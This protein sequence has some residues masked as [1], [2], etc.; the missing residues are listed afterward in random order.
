[1][2][3]PTPPAQ[4]D[5]RT[6]SSLVG[7]TTDARIPITN[8]VAPLH[9]YD[10]SAFAPRKQERSRQRFFHSGAARAPYTPIAADIFP[11]EVRGGRDF[12]CW[13]DRLDW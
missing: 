5:L 3:T 12:G 1:M 11:P 13:L 4:S 8:L 7:P 2:F 10:D 9:A 6:V